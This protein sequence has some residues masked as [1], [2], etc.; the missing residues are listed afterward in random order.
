MNK[1]GNSRGTRAL[2][3]R[4]NLN[5]CPKSKR[6]QITIFVIIALA[7]VA[8]ALL[9]YFVY[10][11]ITST[12]VSSSPESYIQ[13][14]MQTDLENAVEKVSLQ[15]GSTNPGNYYLFNNEKVAYLIYTS[16]FYKLGVMQQP[17]LKQHIESEIKNAIKDKKTECF[18]SLKQNYQG[19]GY[20]VN[21][22]ERDYNVELLPK[23]VIVTFDYSL[24]LIK[25]ATNK[26]EKL[27]VVL[28]NNLYELTTIANSILNSEA[29]YGETEVT[30]YMDYYPTLKVE[31]LIQT[32]GTKIFVIT[33]KTTKDK[34][35]F[36]SRSIAWPPGYGA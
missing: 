35:V 17:M 10:P 1:R 20:E 34:F 23:K 32:D 14:C 4:N 6:S 28:N 27:K 9:I 29:I 25:G 15:G 12:V 18:N 30:T 22:V 2:A 33:D 21:L 3:L 11:K 16:E 24:T 7:I 36:A 19:K 8:V 31:R 5:F 13:S 26:Y